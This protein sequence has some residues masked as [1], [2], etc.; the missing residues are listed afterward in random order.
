MTEDEFQALEDLLRA[1]FEA[2]GASDL[3]DPRAYLVREGDDEL[4]RTRDPKGRLVEMLKALE[5]RLEIE[6]RATF[7]TSM[8]IIT[9][10]IDGPIP[11][12]VIVEQ[13]PSEP[14]SLVDL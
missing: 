7:E 12:Q 6:D 13:I 2:V 9:Q 1:Q 4:R 8:A 14:D 3:A 11:E 10:N 5:R